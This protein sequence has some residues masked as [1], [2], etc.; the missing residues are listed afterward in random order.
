VRVAVKGA[1]GGRE[2]GSPGADSRGV[3]SLRRDAFY[4][5][6]SLEHST[7]DGKSWASGVNLTG[8]VEE[9]D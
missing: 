2:E 9:V 4:L 8:K 5:L 3:E 6:V 1:R 7:Q